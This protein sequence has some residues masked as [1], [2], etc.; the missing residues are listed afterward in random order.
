MAS[1][2]KRDKLWYY[3]VVEIDGI[4]HEVKGCTDKRATEELA[5]EAET[6]TARQRAGLIDTKAESHRDEAARPMSV[7]LDDF[8]AA[9]LA[10]G[11]TPKHATL[12]SDRA[13]RIVALARGTRLDLIDLPQRSTVQQRAIA[14]K[15]LVAVLEDARLSELSPSRIQVA[16]AVLKGAGRVLQTCNHHR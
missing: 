1:F 15:S 10:K 7:H 3:R 8:E 13:R 14:M 16:L 2:R 4:Q 12:Y 6:K 9:L 5:R 11:G